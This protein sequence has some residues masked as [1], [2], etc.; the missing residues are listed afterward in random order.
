MKTSS[1]II[2]ISPLKEKKYNFVYKTTNL[3]NGR[4]YIGVHST[5]NLSDGYIGDGIYNQ[6]DAD[7]AKFQ[8][9]FANKQ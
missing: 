5:N 3:I 2:N 8:V 4:T 9:P 1:D 7:R 6:N